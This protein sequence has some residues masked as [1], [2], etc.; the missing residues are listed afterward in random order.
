MNDLMGT[1]TATYGVTVKASD[2]NLADNLD[3]TC[4]WTTLEE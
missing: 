1:L 3:G 4:V 2:L